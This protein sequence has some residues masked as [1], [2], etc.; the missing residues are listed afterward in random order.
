MDPELLV[1]LITIQ[2]LGDVS[3]PVAS[4]DFDISSLVLM[5]GSAAGVVGSDLYVHTA[6]HETGGTIGYQSLY[7]ADGLLGQGEIPPVTHVVGDQPTQVRYTIGGG[8]TPPATTTSKIE[9]N[10]LSTVAFTR[11][12]IV[13]P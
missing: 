13:D 8:A 12:T 5:S 9:V 10:P 7:D 1:R 2:H 11:I 4:I 3:G 6:F